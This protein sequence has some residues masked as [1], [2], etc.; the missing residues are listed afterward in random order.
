MRRV[1]A[2]R[3]EGAP[4][5]MCSLPAPAK[6]SAGPPPMAGL[7]AGPGGVAPGGEPPLPG[8]KRARVGGPIS[9]N[10]VKMNLQKGRFGRKKFVNRYHKYSRHKKRWK[11]PGA[12]DKDAAGD[13]LFDYGD[14]PD[15]AD[16]GGVVAGGEQ[17]GE[18]GA[19][20][21]CSEAEGAAQQA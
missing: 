19:G 18:E 6:Q 17:G 9:T 16:T 2:G 5:P 7:S 13:V 14:L 12:D 4:A 11:A 3:G 15:E 10:F 1:T 21:S 8:A 20:K